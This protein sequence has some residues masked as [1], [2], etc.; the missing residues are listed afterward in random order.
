MKLTSKDLLNLGVIDEI[1]TEPLGGAHRDR[2]LCLS[3]ARALIQ[4]NLDEMSLM[5][6]DEIFFHRKKKFLSIG[7]SKG[8]TSSLEIDK[9]LTMKES[10][11]QKY[12]LK[13]TQFKTQI[14][15]LIFLLVSILIYLFL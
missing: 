13:F 2:D 9:N 14:I 3:N 7:R 1:I 10:F 5:S 6:R 8:F 11:F 12:L 4:K 15:V